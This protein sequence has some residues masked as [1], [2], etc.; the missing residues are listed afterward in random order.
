MLRHRL[1]KA[2]SA[3]QNLAKAPQEL[4]AQA[5]ESAEKLDYNFTEALG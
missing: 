1:T 4:R 3:P 2:C 5:K